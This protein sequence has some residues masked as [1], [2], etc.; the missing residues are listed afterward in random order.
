MANKLTLNEVLRVFKDVHGDTYDYSLITEYKNNTSEMPIICKEHGVFYKGYVH[1]GKRGQGCPICYGKNLT[2][3]QWVEK[4]KKK[5]N[6]DY[7][8]SKVDYKHSKHKVILICKKH[9][10]FPITPT[11]HMYS[12]QGCPKCANKGLSNEVRIQR[13]IEVHG[14][15]YDFSE[16]IYTK[17]NEDIEFICKKHGKVKQMYDRLKQGQGCRKCDGKGFTNEERIEQAKN[18]HGEKYDYTKYIYENPTTKTIVICKKHGEFLVTPSSHVHAG[19]G[20]PKCGKKSK[21]EETIS[22]VLKENNINYK[23]QFRFDDCIG[24]SGITGKY[25][26]R[27]PFD[28]Y[29]PDFNCCIEYDGRQHYVPVYGEEQLKIQQSI[30]NI[31][32]EYCEKNKIR[33]IRIKSN[34]V[35]NGRG[36]TSVKYIDTEIIKELKE[37]KII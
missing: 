20:C 26:K 31:K 7:D 28:F 18:I 4:V 32:N 29:L 36:R 3:E 19:T 2:T 35:I 6:K 34:R 9:G 21:G 5:H 12:G 16:S 27:L 25:S 11:E 1:H 13:L 8:Y 30:D 33:L 24:N 22:K 15:K 10:E 17:S 37:L 23:V 14:D